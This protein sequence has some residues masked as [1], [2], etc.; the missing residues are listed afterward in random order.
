M[1]YEGASDFCRSRNGRLLTISRLSDIIRMLCYL[2]SLQIEPS[3]QIWVGIRLHD[4]N[5]G[6]TTVTTADG[7][8]AEISSDDLGTFAAEDFVLDNDEERC[9]GVRGGRFFTDSCITFKRFLCTHTY[10]RK[11]E[12]EEIKG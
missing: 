11:R 9:I 8:E 5:N 2:E 6:T 7:E 4:D 10:S 3:Q 1:N 12:G